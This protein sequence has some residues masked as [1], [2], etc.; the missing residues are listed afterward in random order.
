MS[1]FDYPRMSRVEIATILLETQIASINE[2]DLKN[3]NN[4]FISNLY[5]R[6][7]IRLDLLNEED[8]GQVEFSALEQLENP[9]HHVDSARIMSLFVKVRE[10]L[11]LVDCPF[12]FTLKD[13]LMPQGDRTELFLSAIL[14][15]CLHKDTKMNAFVPILDELTLLAEQQKE[16][17]DKISQLNAKLEEYNVARENELPLVQEVD[18]KVRELQQTIAGLNKHQMSLST[19]LKK[20]KDTSKA[21]DGDISKAEFDL[22][23]SVQENANLRSKVVQ[24]PDKLQRALEERKSVCEEAK[25]ANRLAMQHFQ[26]KT[27]LLEVYS[28]TSTKMSKHLSQMQTIHEQVNSAKSIE[29]DF[30]A[31]KIKLSDDKV[32]DK[33]LDAKLVDRQAKAQHLDEQ[34]KAVERERD[35]KCADGAKEYNDIKLEV[36]SRRQDLEIR[37]RKVEAVIS[38]ADSI[39]SKTNV[40]RETGAAKVQQ[41]VQKCGEVSEQFKEYK[42][43]MGQLLENGGWQ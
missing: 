7:L 27:S 3:P 37:Q 14:N 2:N 21:M 43:K 11:H 36:E 18:A 30:K 31:L 6:L 35:L 26:E 5:T 41:I 4:D 12:Q 32:L 42:N 22:V 10:L 38:E 29:K 24:S 17:E 20:L 19:S 34:R 23:Q 8:L 9:D 15:L 40:V 1:K 16:W 33:S 28:K 25:N 13:L 39:T